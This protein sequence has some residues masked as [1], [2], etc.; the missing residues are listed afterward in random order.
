[1]SFP[2]AVQIYSVRDEATADL[3]GTLRAIK[4]MG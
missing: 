3:E 4:E 1:M 2:I